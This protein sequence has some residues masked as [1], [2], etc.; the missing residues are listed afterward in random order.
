MTARVTGGNNSAGRC[1]RVGRDILFHQLSVEHEGHS[2]GTHFIDLPLPFGA[3]PAASWADGSLEPKDPRHSR[4]WKRGPS[5]RQADFTYAVRLVQHFMRRT[6]KV[7]SQCLIGR[8]VDDQAQ[9]LAKEG[10]AEAAIR[11]NAIPLVQTRYR[12]PDERHRRLIIIN[13][14]DKP[15]PSS[16]R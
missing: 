10:N 4:S 6:S 11:R 8:E 14:D 12:L 2:P 3:G 9:R 16:A 7:T 1:R 13:E 5:E 15:A